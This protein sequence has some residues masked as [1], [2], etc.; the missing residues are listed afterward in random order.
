MVM[1]AHTPKC[2]GLLSDYAKCQQTDV[3]VAG[4]AVGHATTSINK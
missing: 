4:V 1:G 3:Y 2:G